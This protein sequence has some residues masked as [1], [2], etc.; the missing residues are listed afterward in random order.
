LG[1]TFRYQ[2][3]FWKGNIQLA[4]GLPLLATVVRPNWALDASLSDE[5]NYFKGWLR[6]GTSIASL[7]KLFNPRI[8][9]G[10]AFK[11]EN[12][13]EI[14]AYYHLQWT[15]YAEPR[16]LRMFEHGVLATYFW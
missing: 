9:A 16:P 7:D 4:A 11:L 6:T 5:T 2:L 1:P 13:R 14:G 10:Y 12:G 8:Q 15:A 3:P